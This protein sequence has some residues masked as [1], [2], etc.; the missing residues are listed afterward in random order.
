MK[1]SAPEEVAQGS[2]ANESSSFLFSL[3]RP[4]RACHSN[5][6]TKTVQF[7]FV[8]QESAEIL[9]FCLCTL[10][11]KGFRIWTTGGCR[12]TG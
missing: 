2:P 10:S 1:S 9:A 5:T 8:S 11:D 3:F 4:R 7:L 6:K 12:G